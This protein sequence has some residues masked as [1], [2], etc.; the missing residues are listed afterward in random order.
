[1][2]RDRQNLADI[3]DSAALAIE[4]VGS[5]NAD[6]FETD[7]VTRDAVL[8]RFVVIGEAVSRISQATQARLTSLPW[9]LTRGM[10]NIVI[11][12]YDQ[13]QLD[14]VYATVR[15]DLPSLVVEIGRIL[16]EPWPD[17]GESP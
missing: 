16:S 14:I 11:H 5:I 15:G 17:E 10:R 2:P 13:V 8:Y 7:E 1:M 4:F 12:E 6:D 9:R 3:R